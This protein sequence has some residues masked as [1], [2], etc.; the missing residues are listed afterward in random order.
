MDYLRLEADQQFSQSQYYLGSYLLL[1]LLQFG[2]NSFKLDGLLRWSGFRAPQALGDVA[3]VA[4][5]P[6]ELLEALDLPQNGQERVLRAARL[7]LLRRCVSL[8]IVTETQKLQLE[9]NAC[10][11]DLAG[12]AGENG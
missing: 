9:C 5:D 11:S 6:A 10:L 7:L 1:D 2:Q 3:A 8:C 12:F 4:P